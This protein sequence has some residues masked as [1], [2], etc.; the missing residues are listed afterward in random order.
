VLHWTT[1]PGVSSIS[2]NN[3]PIPYT[4][5]HGLLRLEPPK[6]GNSLSK[7]TFTIKIADPYYDLRPYIT[8]ATGSAKFKIEAGFMAPL[9]IRNVSLPIEQQG[10]VGDI[11]WYKDRPILS[12]A[13]LVNVYQGVVDSA[14]Y[15]NSENE[16]IILE[17]RLTSPL[18]ILDAS[19]NFYATPNMLQRNAGGVY[20]TAFDNVSLAGKIQEIKWGRSLL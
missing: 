1:L 16:G 5:D 4:P 18:G 2:R 17:I 19:S 9:D 12:E 14:Q 7:D 13:H 6:L 11:L 8:N 10:T 20:D 15:I 3:I